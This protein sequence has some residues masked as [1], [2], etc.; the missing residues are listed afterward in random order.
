MVVLDRSVEAQS[1]QKTMFEGGAE[2]LLDSLHSQLER[3]AGQTKENGAKRRDL[4][5]GPTYY[6]RTSG[7]LDVSIRSIFTLQNTQPDHYMLVATSAEGVVVGYRS[8]QILHFQDEWISTGF[9]Y[10][11][12]R[13]KGV[14]TAIDSANKDF[15]QRTANQ[16]NKNITWETYN[17]NAAGLIDEKRKWRDKE[18]EALSAGEIAEKEVEQKRWKSLWGANGKFGMGENGGIIIPAQISRL[19]RQVM[20]EDL[21]GMEA[22]YMS[23]DANGLFKPVEIERALSEEEKAEL[24]M[25]KLVAFHDYLEKGSFDW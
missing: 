4:G 1:Q 25:R 20:K 11:A 15:M 21:Q 24:K 17:E 6:L 19:T 23:R 8:S 13:K 5:F 22:V 7:G 9:I 14:A 10:S 12:I 3:F 16:W 18:P 2:V